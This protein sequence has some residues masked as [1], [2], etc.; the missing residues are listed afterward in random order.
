MSD[1]SRDVILP[2]NKNCG[3]LLNVAK[4]LFH[5]FPL[6]AANRLVICRNLLLFAR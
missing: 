6:F 2:E 5:Y 4:G 3:T 1:K